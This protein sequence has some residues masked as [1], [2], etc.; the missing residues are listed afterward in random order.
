MISHKR[1]LV[2][3]AILIIVS[4]PILADNDT[5]QKVVSFLESA[6]LSEELRAPLLISAEE[7]GIIRI[8]DKGDYLTQY[9][10]KG[11][12]KSIDSKVFVDSDLNIPASCSNIVIVT[13]GWLDKAGSAWPD[14]MAAAISRKVDPNDWLC[15]CFD[16]PGGARVLNPIDA[17]KYARDIAGPKLALAL[18]KLIAK[19]A[20]I[21]LIAH[22]AGS[23]TINSAAK[24][25]AENSNAEIP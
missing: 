22:S 10:I 14:R 17:A 24:I 3:L 7:S 21:H 12:A 23:W 18:S 8:A 5:R 20:H 6:G 4:A 2:K 13:H 19:P 11:P 25:L 1:I 15:G 9:M 16:W